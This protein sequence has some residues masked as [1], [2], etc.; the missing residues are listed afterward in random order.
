MQPRVLNNYWILGLSVG[1][2]LLL[3]ELDRSL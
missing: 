2:Q 1:K 3:D